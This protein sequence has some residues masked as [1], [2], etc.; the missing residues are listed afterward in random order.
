M[1]DR[2]G[3]K[4]MLI[5]DNSG[6]LK[7]FDYESMGITG[8]AI[9]PYSPKAGRKQA[10]CSPMH[11]CINAHAKRF[12]RSAKQ[13]CFDNF[14]VFDCTQL[15]NIMKEYFRYYN[16]L[17]PHQGIGNTVPDNS[18]SLG[19]G[20]IRKESALFGLYTNYYQSAA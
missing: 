15:R 17:R 8:V 13:E 5:H 2:D 7:W 12:V 14:I 4:T 16:T 3:K 10:S 9:T 1:F 11:P 18:K 20:K 6:E 19:S